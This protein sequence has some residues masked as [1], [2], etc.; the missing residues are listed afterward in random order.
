MTQEIW[1]CSVADDEPFEFT[2]GMQGFGTMP[3]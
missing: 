1:P 3:S 2:K